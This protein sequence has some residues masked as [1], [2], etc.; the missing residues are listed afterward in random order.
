MSSTEETIDI[1]VVSP[2]TSH[3]HTLVISAA[4]LFAVLGVFVGGVVVYGTLNT[5]TVPKGLLV[6]AVPVGNMDRE[7]LSTYIG[8]I[9]QKILSTPMVVQIETTSGEHRTAYIDPVSLVGSDGTV[10]EL[11][12]F[13]EA[14]M[15]DSLLSYGKE[16]NRFEKG[17][18]LLKTR[19]NNPSIA[20]DGVAV[21]TSRLK[22]TL[23]E[24]TQPER[25]AAVNANINI[26]STRPTKIDITP[27]KDGLSYDFD[28]AIAAITN[29]FESLEVPDISLAQ[30]V[31]PPD[32]IATHL[33]EVEDDIEVVL[34]QF[35]VKLAYINTSTNQSEAWTIYP[36]RAGSLLEPKRDETDELYIG[37]RHKAFLAYLED[38]VAPDVRVLPVNAR[39][40]VSDGKVSEFRLAEDGIVVATSS[41]ILTF[42]EEVKKRNTAD[43][44]VSSTIEVETI[45]VTPTIST[46]D[47]N[48]L[49]IT[50]LLG[51]GLSD[52]S[53]S[54]TNRIGNIRNAVEKLDGIIVPPGEEFSTIDYTKPYT[55]EGGYL[56]EKVIKGDSI[57]AEIGGGLCQIGTTLFRMAMNSGLEIT[58]RRNHSLVVGYYNDLENGLPGTDA[59][60]YD[61]APDFR[62]RN[63]TEHYILVEANMNVYSGLLT[64]KL[65]GTDDG[66][67]ASYSRPEVLEWFE[68]AEPR[69]IE[70]EELA[71]GE[72]ECQTSFRGAYTSFTYTRTLAGAEEAEDTIYTSRYRALPKIC[73]IGVEK[74]TMCQ[75]IPGDSTSCAT[76]ETSTIPIE[77]TSTPVPEL[78]ATST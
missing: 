51:T 36:E 65:W 31:M 35:P 57:E 4:V 16:G 46:E 10:Q 66:R 17:W 47:V 24:Q 41:M 38:I 67:K 25:V 58:E 54:P 69:Y 70:T 12:I 71:P 64:F 76:P 15:V 14:M 18:K 56:P 2:R 32:I 39:F 33:L 3:M 48:D 72:T 1:K 49:G 68:P 22:E 30:I 20:V 5:N 19:F 7:T 13:D 63:D 77:F 26:L 34:S 43:A 74:H 9:T 53:G 44:I 29:A 6:G 28:P 62:F 8:E 55:I 59:T 27:S 60:L 42:E 21:V 75:D 73:L 37:L 40:K 52:F 45:A 61:P 23:L 78:I 11:V 50:D